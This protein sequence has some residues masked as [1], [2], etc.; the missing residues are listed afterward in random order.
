MNDMLMAREREI[1][2]LKEQNTLVRTK[3]EKEIKKI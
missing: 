3:Y 2:N 1:V